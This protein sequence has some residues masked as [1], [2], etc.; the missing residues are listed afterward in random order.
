[1]ANFI[2]SLPITIF[3]NL[4]RS[5]ERRLITDGETKYILKKFRES[6]DPQNNST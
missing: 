2:N 6:V 1:M 5:N 3:L 4:Y